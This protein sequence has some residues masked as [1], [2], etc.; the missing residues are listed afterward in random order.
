MR[1]KY[2]ILIIE[3]EPVIGMEIEAFLTANGFGITGIARNAESARQMF[4]PPYPH[5]IILDIKLGNDDGVELANEL[6]FSERAPLI[7]LT[8]HGDANTV[9]RA[10]KTHPSSYLVKP[11]NQQE[12]FAAIDL[13]IFNHMNRLGSPKP[14]DQLNDLLPTPLTPREM[15]VIK[16]VLLGKT[17]REIGASLNVTIH[18]IKSQ[19]QTIFDKFDVRNRTGLMFRINELLGS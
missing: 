10:R 8:A 7:Y 6:G 1:M 5:A 9:L 2:H 19:M 18:T 4:T 11:F 14:L 16:E 3:D 12:L 17:N 15:A 13:G